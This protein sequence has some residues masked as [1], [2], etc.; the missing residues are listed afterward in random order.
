MWPSARRAAARSA[1]PVLGR[2]DRTEVVDD[3]DPGVRR[4]RPDRPYGQAMAQVQ[5]VGGPHGG[6]QVGEARRHPA[7]QVPDPGRAQR[8]VERRPVLHPVA[9]ALHHVGGVRGEVLRG[10]PYGP[11]APVLERLR[12]V[13]VVEGGE[14][15][16]ARLQEAVH[17]PVVEVQARLVDR[18]VAAG[19]DPRPGDREAVGVRAELLDQADV[20]GDPVVVVAGHVTRVAPVDR[21]GGVRERVPDRGG[22]AVLGHGS[23]DLVRGGGDAPGEVRREGVEVGHVL[24]FCGGRGA[25][26]AGGAHFTAPA[27]RPATR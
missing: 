1:S 26:F 12:Q 4:G 7:L 8:L 16:D 20:L 23:L 6:G 10:L 11:A 3:A 9:E 17:E 24:P 22:A 25:A 13:P 15:G 5:V 27:V 14:R 2:L 18:P 19:H 21:A